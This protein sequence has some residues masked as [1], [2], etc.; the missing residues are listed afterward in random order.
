MA[1]KRS[2]AVTPGEAIQATY[3]EVRPRKGE[4]IDRAI[5]RFTRKIRNEGILKEFIEKKTFEK[6]SDK[7]RRL[8]KQA[9]NNC[10]K[11]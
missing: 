11:K 9:K 8:R 10:L 6:K 2:R 5:K 1:R 7:R 3:I 4:P